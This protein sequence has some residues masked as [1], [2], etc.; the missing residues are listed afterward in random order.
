[1]FVVW[2]PLGAVRPDRFGPLSVVS[3]LLGALAVV[4]PVGL[5]AVAAWRGVRRR[6]TAFPPAA[7]VLGLALPVA[8][9]TVLWLVERLDEDSELEIVRS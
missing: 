8:F 2:F 9:V 5:A 4:V 6:S 7:A 3:L 1:M